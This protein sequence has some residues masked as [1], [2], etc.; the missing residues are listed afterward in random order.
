M[1][2]INSIKKVLPCLFIAG[3][4]M[5]LIGLYS[6]SITK[7]TINNRTF[8]TRTKMVLNELSDLKNGKVEEQIFLKSVFLMGSISNIT[9]ENFHIDKLFCSKLDDKLDQMIIDNIESR[10][11]LTTEVKNTFY[12]NFKFLFKQCK[13]AKFSD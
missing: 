6:S 9:S 12:N 3:I 8:D 10:T 1:K 7:E 4:A 2:I 13:D 5:F 11:P